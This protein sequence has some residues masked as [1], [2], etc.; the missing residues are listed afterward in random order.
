MNRLF[1]PQVGNVDA[2]LGSRVIFRGEVVGRDLL[3]SPVRGIPCVYYHHTV[4]VWRQSRSAIGGD[5]FWQMTERDEAIVEFY[6]NVGEQRVIVSPEQVHVKRQNPK[7]SFSIN[8]DNSSPVA[9]N[10]RAQEFTIEPGDVIEVR[11]VLDKVHDLYDEGRGYRERPE[12]LVVRANE[13]GFLEIRV[14]SAE[15]SA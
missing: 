11:G 9:P 2:D 1:P 3:D 12:C 14:L 4:E 10:R 6:L 5:G 7:A 15:R 8:T 13:N